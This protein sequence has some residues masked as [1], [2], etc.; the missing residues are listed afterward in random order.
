MC[1]YVCMCK[2]VC[3]YV[4]TELR[5]QHTYVL[6]I[7]YTHIVLSRHSKMYTVVGRYTKVIYHNNNNNNIIIIMFVYSQEYSAYLEQN[8]GA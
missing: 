2:D 8:T 5:K 4:C 3:M 1:I 6:S 7:G